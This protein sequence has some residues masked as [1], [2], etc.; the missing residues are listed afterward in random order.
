MHVR[1]A[2]ILLDN[3]TCLVTV[4]IIFV[5]GVGSTSA[6]SL[7]S[8][9]HPAGKAVCSHR[10]N[11]VF[12]VVAPSAADCPTSDEVCR[13]LVHLDLIPAVAKVQLL[14]SRG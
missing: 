1:K 9:T 4:A 2:C 7:G 6:P 13:K 14:Q 12:K 5:E 8:E 3:Y 11:F 10:K